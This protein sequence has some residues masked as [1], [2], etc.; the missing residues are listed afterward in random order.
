MTITQLTGRFKYRGLASEMD[1]FNPGG[2]KR[3][4]ARYYCT[5]TKI[6]YDWDGQAWCLPQVVPVEWRSTGTSII[7]LTLRPPM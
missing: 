5:D 2:E 6:T 3:I 1:A 7:P 4:G